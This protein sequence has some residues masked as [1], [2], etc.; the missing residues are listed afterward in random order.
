MLYSLNA[1]S[2]TDPNIPTL[3]KAYTSLVTFMYAGMSSY[4]ND[5]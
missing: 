1:L 2:R 5:H 4:L 3:M